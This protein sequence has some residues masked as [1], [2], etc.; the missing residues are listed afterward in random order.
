M[1]NGVTGEPLAK[2]GIRRSAQPA[3]QA[4]IGGK[5]YQRTCRRVEIAARH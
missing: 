3:A 4:S 1:P 2:A 5:G